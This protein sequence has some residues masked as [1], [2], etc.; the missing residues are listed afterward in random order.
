MNLDRPKSYDAG[1]SESEHIRWLYERA[2][3]WKRILTPD[4]SLMLNLGDV[5]LP[6]Q[7]TMSLYQERL[8]LELVDKL[9]YHPIQKLIWE[10]P[11]KIPAP[12]E[13]VTAKRIRVTPSTENIWWLSPTPQPKANNRNVLV[14]Y[15]SHMRRTLQKGTNSGTRPSGHVVGD[16]AFST[17]NGGAILHCLLTAPN[18]ASRI[19]YL[20]SYRAAGIDP[21]PARFPEAIPNFAI[22]L[23]TEPHDVVFD[24]FAGSLTTAAVAERLDRRFIVCDR[25]RHYLGGGILALSPPQSARAATPN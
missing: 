13:W 25:S 11:A 1:H 8:L 9:G 6:G 23:T 18:T 5:W 19:P 24:P 16:H 14:P 4:G 20:D 7:P 22:L 3:S 15:S 12:A 10:N 21:H 2:E 17:D